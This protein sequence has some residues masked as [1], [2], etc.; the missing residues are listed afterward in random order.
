MF[1]LER[2]PHVN[3]G[4]PQGDLI[5]AGL[6]GLRL[7]AQRYDP[8]MGTRF[9]TVATMWISQGIQRSR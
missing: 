4:A 7:A 2:S 1:M 5:T 6:S 8:D 9:S 3:N